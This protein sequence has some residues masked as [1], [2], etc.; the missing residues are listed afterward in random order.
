M[1][2]PD[3]VEFTAVWYGMKKGVPFDQVVYIGVNSGQGRFTEPGKMTGSHNLGMMP[4]ARMATETD[5]R[6]R[7]RPSRLPARDDHRH[8]R[9]IPAAVQS[10]TIGAARDA[11]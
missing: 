5:F 10:V 7:P 1:T 9:A 8:A 2:G 6:I 11:G 4:P 3:T